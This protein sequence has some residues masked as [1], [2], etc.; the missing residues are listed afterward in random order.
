MWRYAMAA[1]ALLSLVWLEHTR[2][3]T[4]EAKLDELSDQLERL[5]TRRAAPTIVLPQAAG[6]TATQPTPAVAN[7]PSA[8]AAP[9]PGEPVEVEQRAPERVA[10]L[11]EAHE[12]LDAVLARGRL[13]ADDFSAL[14]ESLL[15]VNDPAESRAIGRSI[16]SAINHRE[17]V[18]E[19]L[20][21]IFP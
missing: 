17:L 19:D 20:Q 1:A 11:G 3:R 12:R 10:A 6:A 2:T 5:A 16:A 13:T 9:L 8:P 15:V 7:P 4:I 18:A 21:H 14:H